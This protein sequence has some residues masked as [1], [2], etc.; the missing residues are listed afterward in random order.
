[1]S[2]PQLPVPDREL[3]QLLT[4][5]ERRNFWLSDLFMRRMR[6]W[7]ALW[8]STFMAVLTGLASSR[9]LHV[10]GIKYID[11]YGPQ[12]RLIL[13]ANHRSFFDFFQVMSITFGRTRLGRRVFFPVRSTFF[14]DHPLGA[15]VNLLM[16]G[17]SMFPP[18]LR[19][20]SALPFNEWALD[21]CVAELQV[22]GTVVGIHPEGT[23]NKNDD[24]YRLLRASRGV[25]RIA[26]QSLDTPVIPIFVIGAGNDL[27]EEIRRNLFEPERYPLDVVFG[28]PIRF[29]DLAE[30]ADNPRTWKKAAARCVTAIEALGQVQLEQAQARAA[31]DQASPED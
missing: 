11:R 21:R 18:I 28:P 3:L 31:R 27:L 22:P 19:R 17:M 15:P 13:V 8:N 12:D 5:V 20:R 16:S 26:L 10:H 30:T 24:P 2:R 7:A 1:M 29:D 25:G 23:R 14:Y 6:G 9:R 4:P